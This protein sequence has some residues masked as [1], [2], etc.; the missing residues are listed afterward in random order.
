MTITTYDVRKSK[1]VKA[2]ALIDGVFIKECN[3]KHFMKIHQGYGI[4]E[5]VIQKLIENKCE[6]VMIKTTTEVLISNLIDWLQ[7]GVV[8]DYGN[9]KQ[10]FLPVRKMNTNTNSLF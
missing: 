6:K 10:R 7:F 4:Q 3:S 1:I 2:G 5:D 9:G 8:S